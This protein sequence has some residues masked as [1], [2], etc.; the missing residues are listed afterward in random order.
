MS[1]T[2]DEDYFGKGAEAYALYRP[3]Y[4]DALMKELAALTHPGRA[5]DCATG[6]GQAARGLAKYFDHII[7]TDTSEE[8]LSRANGPANVTFRIAAAESSGL[9][10]DSF[11]LITVATALHWLDREAFWAEVSRVSRDGAVLAFWCYEQPQ[12]SEP[13]VQQWFDHLSNEVLG[14][15]WDERVHLSADAYAAVTVPFE[16]VDFGVFESRAH[17]SQ[18]DDILGYCATWSALERF[19]RAMGYD[20]RTSSRIAELESCWPEKGVD[21]VWSIEPRVFRVE[22][23]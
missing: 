20:P 2:F 17:W 11:D 13:R 1:H 3:T 18:P 9:R 14:G 12:L 5:W 19:R 21:V 4:P 10:A 22:D 8:Q 15:Y 23:A 6:S 16:E 7:A